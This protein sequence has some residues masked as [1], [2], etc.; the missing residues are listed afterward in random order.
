[1]CCFFAWQNHAMTWPPPNLHTANQ[2]SCMS[3]TTAAYNITVC[4]THREEELSHENPLPAND[5]NWN[6]APC[7]EH[8]AVIIDTKKCLLRTHTHF[9]ADWCH[10][11]APLAPLVRLIFL[12]YSL[13]K[14]LKMCGHKKTQKNLI[15]G[16]EKI[17]PKLIEHA[18]YYASLIFIIPVGNRVQN[19]KN[20]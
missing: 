6:G 16:I 4:K 9:V 19:N 3:K 7:D 12:W 1:M 14:K 20:M 13:Q 5:Y 10:A 17:A 8:C 2:E 11:Q 15:P 18:K